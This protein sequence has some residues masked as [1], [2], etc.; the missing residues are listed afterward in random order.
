MGTRHYACAISRASIL[1]GQNIRIIIGD[2]SNSGVLLTGTQYATLQK[3]NGI[4]IPA[5]ISSCGEYIELNEDLMSEDDFSDFVDVCY[6]DKGVYDLASLLDG[7]EDNFSR[8][9]KSN[10]TYTIILEEVYKHLS[11]SLNI[12]DEDNHFTGSNQS[13]STIKGMIDELR[14]SKVFKEELSET[15]KLRDSIE[16]NFNSGNLSGHLK[17]QAENADSFEE[18]IENDSFMNRMMM[19]KGVLS[20]LENRL[21]VRRTN[22]IEDILSKGDNLLQMLLTDLAFH[23]GIDRQNII[24]TPLLLTSMYPNEGQVKF[25]QDMT[26]LLTRQVLLQKEQDQE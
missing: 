26:D 2:S 1:E 15:K 8:D 17:T 24:L 5:T 10:E 3:S 4:S 11:G 9:N 6:S 19:P 7:L 21:D 23:Q 25:H 12:R 14:E 20:F 16:E 13:I 18:F 22:M